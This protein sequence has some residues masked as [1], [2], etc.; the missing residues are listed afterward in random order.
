MAYSPYAHTSKNRGGD[1][2][3][4]GFI[5]LGNMGSGMAGNIQQADYPMVVYD[6]RQAVTQPFVDRGARYAASPA[7][8]AR[9]CE[10]T[11]TSLPGPAEVEAVALGAQGILAGIRAGA[12]DFGLSTSPPTLVREIQPPIWG[13]GGPLAEGPR[14]G[15][16]RSLHQPPDV[17]PANRAPISGP[18]SPRARCPGERWEDWGSDAQSG[19][20]GRW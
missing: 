10:V 7:E 2:E 4:V 12:G 5:G 16:C 11:F 9:Q 1:M 13:P 14:G 19:G 17:D 3:T 15:V 6:L 18:R 8:V 20:D